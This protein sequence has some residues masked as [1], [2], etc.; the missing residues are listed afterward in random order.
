MDNTL[1][2]NSFDQYLKNEKGSSENTRS[3]YL[4]DLRQFSE[5]IEVPLVDAAVDDLEAYIAALKENNRSAATVARNVAS[6]KS[7]YTYCLSC[8]FISVNPA[9][10]IC[11]D[12]IQ[13]KTPDILTGK[14]VEL[15]LDQPKCIDLK[16]YRDKAMLE[17][18]YS[19]GLRVSELIAL[20]VSDVD[21][22]QNT[23][24]CSGKTKNRIVPL[25]APAAKA[26]REYLLFIRKQMIR[27]LNSDVL[28]VNINGDPMSR[29]GFWKVLKQYQKKAGIEKN[30]TPHILRHSF[31]AHQLERG[32]DKRT[33]QQMMGHS[34][35]A[36]TNVYRVF[37][38]QSQKKR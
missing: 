18:L 36:S 1:V 3:S 17:V 38:D 28:F 4:R 24:N 37:V 23:I 11:A 33:V 9:S 7:F 22:A 8:G 35:L 15:L 13:Q 25:S 12:R 6:L 10:H 29:Q 34:D 2:L 21:L 20:K 27:D 30:I 31:A 16:G 26:L 14:E 5:S 32:A 19:T